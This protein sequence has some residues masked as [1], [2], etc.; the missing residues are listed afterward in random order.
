MSQRTAIF[1]AVVLTVFVLVMSS[2]V[3]LN[4]STKALAQSSNAPDPTSAV[5]D[6]SAN[7]TVAPTALPTSTQTPQPTDAPTSTATTVAI[8]SAS[9]A[10]QIAIMVY[11][12]SR[13]KT[14][15]GL[16]NYK[17]KMAY[18]VLLNR[19]TVY[20]DAFDGTVLAK[21]AYVPPA[22]TP[23]IVPTIVPPPPPVTDPNAGNGGNGGGGGGG[24]GVG[25]NQ[26]PGLPGP[27]NPPSGNP[28]G[29]KG[30][31]KGGGEHEGGG[32][33]DD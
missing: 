6:V 1:L 31:G 10:T 26:N 30:G 2:A 21:I 17:G 16:V 20:V 3:A 18:E 29:G 14:A 22:P 4:I 12:N 11:P 15:A 7:V 9:R 27:V 23:T 32:G 13:A 24:G 19:G 8:L 28:G 33:H 25:Q 5:E